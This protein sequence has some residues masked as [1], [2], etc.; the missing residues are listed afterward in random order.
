MTTE[1]PTEL[2]PATERTLAADL[3]NHTWSLLEMPEALIR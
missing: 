2:D 3:F 1:L